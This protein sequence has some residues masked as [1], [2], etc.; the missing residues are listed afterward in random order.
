VDVQERNATVS[1]ERRFVRVAVARRRG[2]LEAASIE[3]EDAEQAVLLALVEATDAAGEPLAERVPSFVRF[4]IADLARQVFYA[5]DVARATAEG[6]KLRPRLGRHLGLSVTEPAPAAPMT[7]A[8]TIA[9]GTPAAHDILVERERDAAVQSA[10]GA[11]LAGRFDPPR[12]DPRRRSPARAD[13]ARRLLEEDPEP[14][15]S[16]AKRHGVTKQAVRA[17]EQSM[18]AALG[19]A[20]EAA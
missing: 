14:L 17:T 10:I 11:V 5:R 1:R 9:T 12:T 3:P 16:I 4:K 6:R 7:E 2:L 13:I 8:E 20:L 15:E 19:R 18:L